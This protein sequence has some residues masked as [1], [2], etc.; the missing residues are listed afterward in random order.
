MSDGL[1][2][3]KMKMGAEVNRKLTVRN[4]RTGETIRMVIE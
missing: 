4:Q 3:F 2:T 1:E